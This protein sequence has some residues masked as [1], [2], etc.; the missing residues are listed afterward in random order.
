MANAAETEMPDTNDSSGLL[1][2]TGSETI[3]FADRPKGSTLRQR[4][5]QDINE[6]AADYADLFRTLQIRPDHYERFLDGVLKVLRTK[7]IKELQ[8]G[9]DASIKHLSSLVVRGYRT[10]IWRMGSE[11]LVGDGEL[12]R[13]EERLLHGAD[14]ERYVL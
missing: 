7:H 11:W 1:D 10:I 3:S 13:G 14:N 4:H 12:E 8:R 5:Q 9:T 2:D 6:S